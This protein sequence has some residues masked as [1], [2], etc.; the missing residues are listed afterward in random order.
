MVKREA[1][2]VPYKFTEQI[3]RCGIQVETEEG[4]V[5][6]FLPE[7]VAGILI[8]E[9][10]KM[11]EA[12]LGHKIGY[13]VVTAPA[14]FNDALRSSSIRNEAARLHGGFSAV[15][16]VD[17]QVAAAAA[18]RLHEKRGDGKV[19]LV[20][21]LGGRTTHATKFKFKD[22]SGRL[23][24]ERHDAYLGG[25]DFTNR[26]VDYFV[27]LIKE[28]HHQDIRGDEG[29]LGK[30]RA[31]CEMAKKALSNREGVLVNVGSVLDQASSFYEDFTRAKFEELNGDL[32]ARV[33]EMVEMVVLGGAP[34]SQLRSHQDAI[35]EIILV[36]GS[37][38]IPM[39]AQLIEDYFHGRGLIRDEEAVIRGAALLSRLESA[40]YVD[41]CYNGGVSGP[42]WL[43]S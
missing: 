38:R 42:L 18:Y 11:A 10:K 4:Q 17:E 33:I 37:M 6:N 20:V 8:A 5:M 30:L 22:G 29:A 7:R 36:G 41:E 32:M 35:D 2:L 12:R 9:L 31:D 25:D 23:L 13:A 16:V 19:V 43:A 3:G 26:V 15:N 28:K 39:V 14:H 21:H 27:E 34:A 40:R 24:Q 1:D